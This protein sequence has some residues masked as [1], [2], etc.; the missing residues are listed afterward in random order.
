MNAI[1]LGCYLEEELFQSLP[2]SYSYIVPLLPIRRW[3]GITKEN[4]DAYVGAYIFGPKNNGL[5]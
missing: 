3:A 1:R 5:I 4:F 2:K